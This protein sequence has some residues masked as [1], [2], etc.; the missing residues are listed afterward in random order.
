MTTR[1]LFSLP[2]PRP[3]TYS[4]CLLGGL[5]SAPASDR[6]LLEAFTSAMNSREGS[7]V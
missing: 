5:A 2:F 7:K 6:R 3:A 1:H 4:P